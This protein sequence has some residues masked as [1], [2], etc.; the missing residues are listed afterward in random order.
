M[1]SN[2]K[3][4]IPVMLTPYSS[5]GEIDYDGLTRITEFYLESGSA[6]LFANCLSSEMY[7]LT[8]SER[9]SVTRHVVRTVNGRV[10]VV[11][12]GNFGRTIHEQA[13]FVNRMAD[14][15]VAAVIVVTGLLA[16]ENEPDEVFMDN[17]FTLMRLTSGISV[18]FYECPLPYKRILKA[19]QLKSLL[20]TN[21]VLY[22]KD[23][24]L[25]IHQVREKI[26]VA[27]GY[28]FAFYDAYLG[29]A[30]ESLMAGSDGL[31]CIQGNFFPEIIVW[32]CEHFDDPDFTA[33]VSAVQEFLIANMD[34]MHAVYPP[35][36][37]YY[38]Q[39]RGM[40]ISLY[41]RSTREVVDGNVRENIDKL[42][43]DCTKL[44]EDIGIRALSF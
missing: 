2:K 15:G 7:D 25:D 19:S 5:S 3:G 33:E 37:K 6:G 22:H 4:F 38:L 11:A 20:E 44:H 43:A 27:R 16:E 30:V 12:T 14:T 28:D 24:C 9:L 36:A 39:K 31:S 13:D 32:L 18:G 23:T 8:P 1:K 35:I 41:C 29:H 42:F 17:A 21:R 34:V 26:A 10:P 40:D